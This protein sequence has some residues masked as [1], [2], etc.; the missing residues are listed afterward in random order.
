MSNPFVTKS[1]GEPNSWLKGVVDA[2]NPVQITS[3][4][5]RFANNAVLD[6]IGALIVRNGGTPVLNLWADIGGGI[7]G[8]LTS[9]VCI[10][11]FGD[12][13]L[14]VGHHVGAQKMYLYWVPAAMNDYYDLNKVL[15]GSSTFVLPVGTLWTG[16]PDPVPVTIA[17]GLG[18]A[19]I[20]HSVAGSS[21]KTMKLDTTVGPPAVLS[22]FQANLDGTGVKDT[23]FR[24]VVSFQ[25]HLWGWGY[26]SQAAGDNDRPELLRFSTPFFGPMAQADNFAVGHRVRSQRERIVEAKVA[27]EALYVGTNFQVWPVTGFGRNSWDKSRPADDSYGF[28]AVGA[29]VAGPNGW[30]YYWS[31]RGLLRIH[32]NGPPEPLW[33]RIASMARSVIDDTLIR[34]AYDYATDQ[35][36]VVFNDG[37]GH[38]SPGNSVLLAYDTIREAFLGPQ[39]DMGTGVASMGT[40]QSVFTPPPAGA[41][42]VAITTLVGRSVATANWTPGDVG[43]GVTSQIEIRQQ[44]G[45]AWTVVNS[46]IAAGV[47]SFRFTGL[48]PLTP[49]EWRVKH[50]RGGVSS[51]YL[52]PVAGSQF[53][54]GANP[55]LPTGITLTLRDFTF[56][57]SVA[58]L[59]VVSWT[60]T[61]ENAIT[62]VDFD[63]PLGAPPVSGTMPIQGTAPPGQVSVG[64][65]FSGGAGTYYAQILAYISDASGV[66]SSGYSGFVTATYPV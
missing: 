4:A 62:E 24:G 35:V 26:G 53:T 13:A 57:G 58:H 55:L 51:A 18:V 8:R 48:L 16:A 32:G 40:V 6:G 56:G 36:L 3:G 30:L 64:G 52:G 10:S 33:P 22:A 7:T 37:S 43:L 39:G 41:P 60:D 1:F 65:N 15:Q 29:T 23:Y 61:G 27:G 63:G 11:A 38:G 46:T 14:I 45:T 17:E 31:H 19:Y 20:A 47:A 12:G 59:T 50:V 25:E 49:Y 9:V 44:G 66:H 54:T 28:A 42:S 34:L 5:L 2:A 21:F